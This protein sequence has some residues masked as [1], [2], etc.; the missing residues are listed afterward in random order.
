VEVGKTYLVRSG[1]KDY[2][3]VVVAIPTPFTVV[4]ESASWVAESGRWHEFMRHGRAEGMEIEPC[5]GG[6]LGIRW[7][8]WL[9]WPHPLFTEAV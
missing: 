3:G 2:V 1:S 6:R 7:E 5:G 8:E 4:L 9:D